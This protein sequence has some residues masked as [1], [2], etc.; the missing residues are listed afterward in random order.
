MD[1]TAEAGLFITIDINDDGIIDG[2]F[3]DPV[4]GTFQTGTAGAAGFGLSITVLEQRLKAAHSP[5]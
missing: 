2:S 1:K 5:N 4:N 3:S